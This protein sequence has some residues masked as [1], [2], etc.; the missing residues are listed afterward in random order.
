[1]NSFV[2]DLPRPPSKN[3]SHGFARGRVFRSKAY[4][5]WIEQANRHLLAKGLR[6]R[7]P[8]AGKFDCRIYYK[9]E[10]FRGDPQ[11]IVDCALDWLQHAGVVSNDK[12]L[13]CLELRPGD[14]PLEC[15]FIVEVA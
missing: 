2:I 10:G 7:D 3:A 4:T 5:Q 13:R 12:N 15:R 9:A 1:M 6:R 11:N 8:I 14:I